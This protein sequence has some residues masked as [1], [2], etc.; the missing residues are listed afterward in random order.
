MVELVHSTVIGCHI[1]HGAY[2]NAVTACPRLPPWFC[3]S[4]MQQLQEEGYATHVFLRMMEPRQSC[5]NFDGARTLIQ[6]VCPMH[7]RDAASR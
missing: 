7:F 5:R 4:R 2:C 6:A 3:K 1:I